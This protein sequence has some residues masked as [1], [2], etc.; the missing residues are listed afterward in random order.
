LCK[1]KESL[2]QCQFSCFSFSVWACWGIV[3]TTWTGNAAVLQ[4]SLFL[5]MRE[6]MVVKLLWRLFGWLQILWKLIIASCI[7][8]LLR[9][10]VI[11]LFIFK[12]LNWLVI[13]Y[14]AWVNPCLADMTW[15]C[16][17]W[18]WITWERNSGMLSFQLLYRQIRAA[19]M[20][21]Y[22][23]NQK[24]YTIDLWYNCS[25]RTFGCSSL[26]I[27]DQLLRKHILGL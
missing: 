20:F 15:F 25:Y 5:P 18:M 1:T 23:Y 19:K 7:L 14:C 22:L 21:S 17:H 11:Y 8:I 4:L 3:S 16:I 12:I 2:F 10:K 27:H 26:R 13:D 6:N 9:Y 24:L